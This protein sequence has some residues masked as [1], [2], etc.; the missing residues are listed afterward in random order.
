M[1]R[2][3]EGTTAPLHNV[4]LCMKALE[5]A[6]KRPSHLPGMVCFYGPSGWGKTFAACH[7]AH[8]YE[9][10]YVECRSTW[11]RKAVLAAILKKMGVAQAR[12]IYEMTEQIIDHLRITGRALIVDEMDHIVEKQAVNIIRD[13]YDGS[14]APILLIGEEG[15]PEKLEKW[16]R[17][18]GRVL[19]WVPAQP[20]DMEDARVLSKLYCTKATVRDDLLSL[21]VNVARG[22]VRRMCVNIAR[23][24]EEAMGMGIEEIGL[25]EWGKKPLWTGEPPA[26]RVI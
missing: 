24:E 2:G 11:S 18:H 4:A 25:E 9:G 10:Y 13:L 1:E 21:I 17:F 8:K 23:V 5:R 19:D 6:A 12:T 22:S 3:K 7:A 20:A 16:E 15:I 26:R 14:G